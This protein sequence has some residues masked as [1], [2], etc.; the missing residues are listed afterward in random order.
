MSIVVNKTRLP[1][2]EWQTAS[3]SVV[4]ISDARKRY[5]KS[6]SVALEPIQ[7]LH[8]YSNPWVGGAGKNLVDEANCTIYRKYFRYSNGNYYWTASSDSSSVAIPCKP[9]TTY[10][11]S[12]GVSN[13][14]ILRAGTINVPADSAQDGTQ[15]YNFNVNGSSSNPITITTDAYS[16]TLVVQV[17]NSI[18]QQRNALLQ[19]EIGSTA[20]AY[21]PYENL[22]P[23]S[24]HSAVTLN[25]AGA[26][27]SDNPTSV[28]VQLGQTVYGGTVDLVS[29]VMTVDTYAYDLANYTGNAVVVGIDNKMYY[30]FD[31]LPIYPTM[32]DAS[33]YS[34]CDKYAKASITSSTTDVGI[35]ISKA[36]SVNHRSISFRPENPG[37]YSATTIKSFITDTLGGLT[38]CYKIDPIIIQLTPNQ[39][40]ML[41]RNNTIWSDDGIV[42]VNYAR[43]HS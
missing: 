17:N 40:E 9:N 31:N 7:D 34:I 37:N 11:I 38:V 29:G 4:S 28:T 24:G 42:T 19:I 12:V 18:L 41:M 36:S 22:C 14:T 10:T 27:Q 23:I 3:G 33:F 6:L 8:G 43:I 39:I 16:E 35:R 26:S 5:A 25:H 1:V 15:I 20:T 32:N 2:T 13:V 21:E 30:R